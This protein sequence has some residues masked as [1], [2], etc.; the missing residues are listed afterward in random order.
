ML[1]KVKFIRFV[2]TRQTH[3]EIDLG[4]FIKRIR[5]H[6]LK[7]L[8]WSLPVRVLV[9]NELCEDCEHVVYINHWQVF[10]S[11]FDKLRW[12]FE[13]LE[14]INSD[15]ELAQHRARGAWHAQIHGVQMNRSIINSASSR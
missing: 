12:L 7:Q 2:E 3:N 13:K 8:V 6:I 10:G 5:M 14:V 11:S 4:D 1:Y 15:N 9:T